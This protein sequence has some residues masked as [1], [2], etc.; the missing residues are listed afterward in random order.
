MSPTVRLFLAQDTQGIGVALRRRVIHQTGLIRRH[1]ARETLN[2]ERMRIARELHDSLEQDLLGITMQ[3]TATEKLLVGQS[4]KAHEAL[5]LAA[6]MVR[7]S[8]AETHRTVW[9]LR[10]NGSGWAFGIG[11]FGSRSGP[12]SYRCSGPCRASF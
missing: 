2:E 3:L 1:V 4:A 5:Q 12:G 11:R 9:D 6:A 7:R 10:A 8:Q